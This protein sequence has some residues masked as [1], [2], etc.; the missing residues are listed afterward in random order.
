M[1]IG[2]RSIIMWELSTTPATHRTRQRSEA[3]SA[4]QTTVHDSYQ[5]LPPSP[6]HYAS[7]PKKTHNRAGARSTLLRYR[8]S[9]DSLTSDTVMAYFDPAKDTE[10]IMDSSPV[11]LGTILYQTDRKGER[12]TISYASRALSDVERRYS[13]TEWEALAIEWSCELFHLYI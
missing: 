3:Y 10:L 9:I 2:N 11:G 4:W 7:S 13:Q 12:H 5:T 8:Q 6:L 1:V